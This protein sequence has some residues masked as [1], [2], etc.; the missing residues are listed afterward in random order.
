[1]RFDLKRPCAECPF[2]YSAGGYL[3]QE[4]AIEIAE[5]ILYGNKTFTCHK[6][7]SGNY[8]DDHY[9]EPDQLAEFK[10]ENR[11]DSHDECHAEQYSPGQKDQHCAGALAF[12]DKLEAGEIKAC[13]LQSLETQ[14]APAVHYASQKRQYI[15]NSMLQIAER[16]GLRQRSRLDPQSLT[17][18]YNSVDEMAQGHR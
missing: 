18:V 10:P 11:P 12:Y 16:L 13:K 14:A 1:M 17:E 5:A 15:A 7:I 3:T 4:R 2:K 8:T 9:V 6:T